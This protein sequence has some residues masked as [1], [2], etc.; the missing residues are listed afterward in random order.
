MKLTS[1]NTTADQQVN[2]LLD[3]ADHLEALATASGAKRAA[4]LRAGAAAL[5]AMASGITTGGSPAEAIEDATVT[6]V[7]AAFR[8]SDSFAG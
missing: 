8:S 5:L 7:D 1:A 6:A 3:A 2:A 4:A